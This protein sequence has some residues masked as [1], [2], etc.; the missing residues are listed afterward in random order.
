MKQ[1]L[2]KELKKVGTTPTLLAKHIGVN[3]GT[4]YNIYNNRP[5]HFNLLYDGWKVYIEQKE[6]KEFRADFEEI[7][8]NK[9]NTETSAM[10][11]KQVAVLSLAECMKK[12]GID[13]L[14]ED[15]TFNMQ[16][17][18]SEPWPRS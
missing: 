17:E 3:R 6:L 13:E 5:N 7:F 15:F 1:S 14:E 10:S 8:Q 16:I 12:H 4:I 18:P 2:S 11:I 9:I